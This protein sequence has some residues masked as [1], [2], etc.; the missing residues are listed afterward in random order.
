MNHALSQFLN[1]KLQ[2]IPAEQI[3]RYIIDKWWEYKEEANLTEEQADELLEKLEDEKGGH[4]PYSSGWPARFSGLVE[5][6]RLYTLEGHINAWVAEKHN[7][8][9]W[10][11]PDA[12]YARYHWQILQERVNELLVEATP[13]AHHIKIP[14]LNAAI[15]WLKGYEQRLALAQEEQASKTVPLAWQGS[16]AELAELGY[17]L[18]ES[19][20]VAAPNRAGAVKKLGELFGVAL[21]DNPAAHL[22]TIQKRKTGAVLTPLLDKLK[23]AFVG[24]LE[25]K[26]ESEALNRAKR[27]R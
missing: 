7:R 15:N 17:S 25:R 4:I 1:L 19:G 20:V 11:L 10:Q 9:Y 12:L 2:D 8:D 27:R 22:Q 13:E 3:H 26:A 6:S 14:R 24:Y 5:N 23:A 21:G 18:L 16:K